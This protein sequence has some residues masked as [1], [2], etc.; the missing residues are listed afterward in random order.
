MPPVKW[1]R[2]E[3][4]APFATGR[5]W[6]GIWRGVSRLS[7]RLASAMCSAVSFVSVAFLVFGVARGIIAVS[8]VS[9]CFFSP[10]FGVGS[11][12]GC[13]GFAASVFSFAVWCWV[14]SCAVISY[15]RFVMRVQRP[16]YKINYVLKERE[17]CRKKC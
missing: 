3:G 8:V 5:L 4:A 12:S 17:K 15:L 10:A 14:F 6:Q 1:P 7:L 13:G 16:L 11:F 2:G 9:F